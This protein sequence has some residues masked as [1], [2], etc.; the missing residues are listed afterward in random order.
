VEEE[1]GKMRNQSQPENKASVS[2]KPDHSTFFLVY[3]KSL[4]WEEKQWL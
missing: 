3:K 1:R 2:I 4:F